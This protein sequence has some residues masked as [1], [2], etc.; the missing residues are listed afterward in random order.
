MCN[1]KGG[2]KILPPLSLFSVDSVD[3]SVN[4]LF[5]DYNV[6]NKSCYKQKK[7]YAIDYVIV[8][9]VGERATDENCCSNKD[10]NQSQV[11]K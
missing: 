1:S 9:I 3:V 4:N 10:K 2:K 11:F 6:R 8:Y 5:V 7:C